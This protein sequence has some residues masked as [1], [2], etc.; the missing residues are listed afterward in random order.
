MISLLDFDLNFFSGT[1]KY[2]KNSSF[3]FFSFL[4]TVRKDPL[5][6]SCEHRKL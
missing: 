5:V 1:I 4:K 2:A 3:H 6:K